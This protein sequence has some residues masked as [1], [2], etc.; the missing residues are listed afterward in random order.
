MAVKLSSLRAGRPLSTTKIPGT[1]FCQR[2]K[3]Q[4]H[5]AAVRIRLIE[6]SSGIEP[7]CS[8]VPQPATLPRD[9]FKPDVKSKCD[10]SS[11]NT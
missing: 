2:L 9:P 8:I 5:S 10:L 6:T 11:L 1:H 4:G 7:A 3:P